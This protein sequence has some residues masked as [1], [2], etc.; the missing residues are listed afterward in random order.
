[1]LR[2]EDDNGSIESMQPAQPPQAKRTSLDRY[3]AAGIY[4]SIVLIL[5]AIC[6]IIG[7]LLR[8]SHTQHTKWPL[9][10]TGSPSEI[11]SEWNDCGT[12]P[13]EAREKNCFF[14]LIL[15][16]WLYESCYDEDMMNRY[17]TRG[18]HRYWR[19]RN[20]TMEMAEDEARLGEY[21][22]I[23][24]DG[25]FHLQ[26]C[27]YLMDMQVRSY[28]TG[29]PIEASIYQYEH[30]THCVNMALAHDRDNKTT[31]LMPVFGICGYPK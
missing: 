27:V 4:L 18:K 2:T 11:F 24:T 3:T 28:V 14:D 5:S 8:A 19:D 9:D 12:N 31:R 29:R 20:M 1:M 21:S 16:A 30:S 26:H 13:V 17:L 6:V 23:W 10:R 7:S 25:E 15:S 22:A